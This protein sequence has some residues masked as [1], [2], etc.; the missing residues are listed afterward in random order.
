MMTLDFVESFNMSRK[1]A[2]DFVRG[3][4]DLIKDRW[5]EI[6]DSGRDLFEGRATDEFLLVRLHHPMAIT[7]GRR[8][9][10]WSDSN[11][12]KLTFGGPTV[13]C[14]PQSE[15]GDF[16]EAIN[17]PIV[18]IAASNISRSVC[19]VMIKAQ[20]EDIEIDWRNE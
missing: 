19:R 15:L 5:R 13:E 12:E 4:S 18:R 14:L 2:S 10:R 11:I 20:Q 9:V 7:S 17:Q 8:G 3:T 1:A 16:L 6:V